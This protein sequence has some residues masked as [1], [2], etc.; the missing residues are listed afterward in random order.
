MEV[1]SLLKY[2]RTTG[3]ATT[4]A[5]S[6][7][8]RASTTASTTTTTIRHV[9]A[10]DSSDDDEENNEDDGPFFDLEFAVP[11]DETVN[12]D[13]DVV[14][15]D[16]S[17]DN[18]SIGD[19]EEAELDF[20]VDSSCSTGNRTDPNLSLSPSDDL[21]FNSR[22]VPLEPSELCLNSTEPHSISKLQFP[23]ALLKPATKLRVLML[24]FKKPKSIEKIETRNPK[25]F[26]V[27]FKV[28]EVP[29]VSLFTRENSSR[30][31]RKQS[32]TESTINT[33]EI[34]STEEKKF[35]KDV[36][37][38]YLNMVKPLYFKVSKKS[39]EKLTTTGFSGQLNMNSGS[40]P[41]TSPTEKK[42]ETSGEMKENEVNVGCVRSSQ[43]EN[44]IRNVRKHL[45]KSRS[46]SSAVAAVPTTIQ[47]RRH[48]DSLLQQQDGIQSAILHCKRSFTA[49]RDSSELSRCASDPTHEKSTKT[50][51]SS[52]TSLDETRTRN[53]TM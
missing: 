21:F 51:N 11:D 31:H 24:G 35:A 30:N 39:G 42:T 12:Q 53:V 14:V 8:I 43:K 2:W 23:N 10:D 26:T 15:S 45:G 16:E 17:D 25:P 36:L 46:A 19:H 40:S 47:S 28:E 52:R 3:G 6:N 18:E 38:K 1:F 4:D 48:D 22:F 33:E 5:T 50:S 29:I 20:T 34:A 13:S 41:V 37:Q 9:A 49:S 44:I 7:F 27:K 32:T